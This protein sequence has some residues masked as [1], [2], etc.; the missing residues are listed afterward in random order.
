MFP[1]DGPLEADRYFV[2]ILMDEPHGTPK[3][4]GFSTGG[5]V[6][7]PAAGKVIERIAPFLGVQR[8]QELVTIAS[9]PKSTT[10]E[11]GL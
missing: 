3:S 4:F 7:A 10:P 11:A 8:K 9:Q 2:L 6:G 5:W 1:T